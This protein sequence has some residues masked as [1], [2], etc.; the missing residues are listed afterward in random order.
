MLLKIF[1]IPPLFFLELKEVYDRFDHELSF[2][3][4][5]HEKKNTVLQEA[6]ASGRCCK[7]KLDH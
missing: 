7:N 3:R 6:T 1:F 4:V 5:M 2:E